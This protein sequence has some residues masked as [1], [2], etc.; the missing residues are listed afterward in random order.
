MP[1]STKKSVTPGTKSE[2]VQTEK[3]SP[4][5]DLLHAIEVNQGKGRVAHL[6]WSPGG[7]A[8]E[9]C[10]QILDI[11]VAEPLRRQGLGTRMMEQ[12]VSDARAWFVARESKLGNLWIGVA[13]KNHIHA[14]AFLT[15]HGFHHKGTLEGLTRG[16]DV[17]VYIKSYR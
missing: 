7:L 4:A 15:R 12:L 6:L 2:P 1:K 14:R 10:C 8:S 13:H 3:P 16:Q 5:E 17:L 9:G 11:Q